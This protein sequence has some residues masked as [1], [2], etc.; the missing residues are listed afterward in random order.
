MTDEHDDEL[1]PHA[2]IQRTYVEGLHNYTC[3]CGEHFEDA[4]KAWDHLTDQLKP[5]ETVTDE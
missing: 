2:L 4:K 5:K 3:V 1:G